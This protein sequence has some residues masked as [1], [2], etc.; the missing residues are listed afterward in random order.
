MFQKTDRG[1]KAFKLKYQLDGMQIN[2]LN[3]NQNK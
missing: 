3:N 1:K 2:N